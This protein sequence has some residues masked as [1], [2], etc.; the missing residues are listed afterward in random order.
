MRANA[1]M[2]LIACLSDT[3]ALAAP[4]GSCTTGVGKDPGTSI[5][6]ETVGDRLSLQD[7][8]PQSQQQNKAPAAGLARL[9]P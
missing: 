4:L 6:C 3:A 1:L 2:S 5:P 8:M 7:H 9:M